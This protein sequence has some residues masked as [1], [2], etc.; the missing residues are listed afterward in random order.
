[1]SPE[2]L[3]QCMSVQEALE[4][5]GGYTEGWNGPTQIKFSKRVMDLGKPLREVTVGELQDIAAAV[6]EEMKDYFYPRGRA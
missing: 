5:F 6:A 3:A 2:T 1:M 4:P